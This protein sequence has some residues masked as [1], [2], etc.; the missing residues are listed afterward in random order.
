MSP[1][2][3]HAHFYRKIRISTRKGTAF[4]SFSSFLTT[5]EI[6]SGLQVVIWGFQHLLCTKPSGNAD[7]KGCDPAFYLFN[8]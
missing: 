1:R 6:K 3:D 8:Y 2:N 5:S 7:D 4:L